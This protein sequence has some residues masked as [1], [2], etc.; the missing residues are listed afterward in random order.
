MIS[1]CNFFLVFISVK[2]INSMI[3]SMVVYEYIIEYYVV[4]PL[5]RELSSISRCLLSVD[6]TVS[7][8]DE[9]L[10]AIVLLLI[11]SPKPTSTSTSFN[12]VALISGTTNSYVN[13]GWN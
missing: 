8:L 7:L 4:I 3:D 2:H 6:G 13:L 10:F 9:M 5:S 12:L 1:K 11:S